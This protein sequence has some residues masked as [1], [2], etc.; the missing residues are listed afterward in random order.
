[1]GKTEFVYW[2]QGALEMSPE[3]LKNGMTPQQVQTIQD[4]LDLVFTKV[5]PDRF[6][7]KGE[8]VFNPLMYPNHDTTGNPPPVLPTTTCDD[9]GTKFC[10][11]SPEDSSVHI[12]GVKLC[13]SLSE[14]LA[15]NVDGEKEE[16][17]GGST[18]LNSR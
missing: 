16:W 8:R 13:S 5:T 11:S 2:L 15:V 10:S 9:G 3:M 6:E 17:T 1:M 4:H 7:E 18:L 14:D 12:D